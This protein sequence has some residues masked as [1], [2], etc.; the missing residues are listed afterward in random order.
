MS[1]Q[2]QM[3]QIAVGS[4]HGGYDLKELIKTHL[5]QV[6]HSVT[7]CG[8]GGTEA[9][10]YPKYA[11]AVASLV[12]TGQA[13]CGIMVDRAGIGSTM[14]AN[15]LPGIRAELCYDLSSARG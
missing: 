5:Q 12:A 2:P 9:V 10:D 14:A 7:D 3:Q 11:Q 13:D 15:K 4:D 6:G 1:M 8:T